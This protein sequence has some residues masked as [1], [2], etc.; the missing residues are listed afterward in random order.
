M[1][2]DEITLTAAAGNGG[3][4]VVR[5]RQEKFKPKAGPA[6]GDGG[7]GGDVYVRAVRDHAILARYSGDKHFEAGHGGQ[8][9][10]GSKTGKKGTDIFI[11]VPVGSIV[12]D[13]EK[14]RRVEL[15]TEGETVLFYKGG[16]GGL[17]NEYFKSSTNR[18]PDRA[19]SGRSGES[20]TLQVTVSLVVDVGLIGLPNAGKSTLLNALT[21]ARSKIGAYPFTTLEPQLGELYGFILADIPGLIAGAAA[22][23]G[24]GHRFLR[25]SARTRMLLHIVDGTAADISDSYYTIINEL[26][27]FSQDLSDKEQWLVIN[28]TDQLN[29]TQIEAIKKVVDKFENR[30][31]FVSAEM[32]DGL[33]ELR[34]AL[35]A[36]LRAPY[37]TDRIR[38]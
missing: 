37:N 21:G 36:H 34:D 9:L 23:K 5:W 28:K 24:L 15:L 4:G 14:E 20:G 26:K 25:H 7:R 30:V 12:E 8:G 18:S 16:S 29:A 35:V 31:F 10:E 27:L 2:I 6:G 13:T 17:G 33:K 19:T 1:F 22:G 38:D 11:D 3:N 32:G